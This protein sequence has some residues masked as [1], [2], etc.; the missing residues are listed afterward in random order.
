MQQWSE[1]SY[2]DYDLLDNLENLKEIYLGNSDLSFYLNN[3]YE[4]NND[5][6]V[7]SKV[8]SGKYRTS[9]QRWL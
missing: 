5:D 3:D 6:F 8:Y 1:G 7:F 2:N 9:N 4:N